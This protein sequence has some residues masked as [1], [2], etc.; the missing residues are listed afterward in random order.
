MSSKRVISLGTRFPSVPIVFKYSQLESFF[1]K[2]L[3]FPAFVKWQTEFSK[4]VSDLVVVNQVIIQ[5]LDLF[6]SQKIGFLKFKVDL[7]WIEDGKALPGIVFCRGSSVA[8]LVLLKTSPND[9]EPFVVL[10]DQPRIPVGS[11]SFLE[12]P[13][14]MVDSELN[15]AG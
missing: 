8:C 3:V 6:G 13:A 1:D 14:G 11:M 7:N 15:F 5:D 4:N 9:E 12:L 2:I 10:V